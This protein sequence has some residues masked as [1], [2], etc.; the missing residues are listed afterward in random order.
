MWH[1]DQGRLEYFQFD[2]LRKVASFVLANDLM[3]STRGK[4]KAA[5]GLP[6]SVPSSHSPW[7]NYAR[8]YKSMF[9]VATK[10]GEAIATPVAAA[11]AVPGQ[12]TSDE[13]FHFIAMASTEPSPALNNYSVA[14]APKYPLLFAL[15]Y[16]LMRA[17]MGITDLAKFD[18]VIGA[19][20]ASGYDGSEDDSAFLQ[21][22]SRENEF[23]IKGQS[24]ADE[25]RRQARESLRVIAQI[26]YLHVRGQAIGLSIAPEDASAAFAEL[27][28]LGGIRK[29][30]GDDEI[31]RRASLFAGGSTLD[32]FEYPKTVINEAVA[33]GFNEGNKVEK[34]HLIIERNAKLR[35]EYFAK[36]NPT[37]CDVCRLE[38]AATYPWTERVIDL[39]HLLPLS[40]GTRTEAAGTVLTDLLPV[41]PTCH[42]AIHRFYTGWLKSHNKRDFDDIAEAKLA[43]GE[44]KNEMNGLHY[45]S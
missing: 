11:L 16:L 17:S 22:A 38:T 39:H 41:C 20:A 44:M 35:T 14:I 7:R 40:S 6:F 15:K 33:A 43:I 4:L 34:T 13:F 5:I 8:V 10:N 31:L 37:A 3:K 32:F 19:Y 26:S 23:V 12:I 27:H 28:P 24:I 21:L 29:P 36:F 9:L 30:D 45:A 25:L 1:W 18:E 42:R 2:N